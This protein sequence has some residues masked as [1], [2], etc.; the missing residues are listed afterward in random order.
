[1]SAGQKNDKQDKA[2][3]SA[4]KSSSRVTDPSS[5][6]EP[7]RGEQDDDGRGRCGQTD[8]RDMHQQE[9]SGHNGC[10]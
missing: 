10:Q 5:C 3:A 1:V 4:A 6:Q 9:K 8:E 7:V 2:I